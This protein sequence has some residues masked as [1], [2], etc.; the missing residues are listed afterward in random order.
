MRD[1][2]LRSTIPDVTFIEY[3]QNFLA[4]QVPCF[5]KVYNTR[6]KKSVELPLLG[7]A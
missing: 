7:V 1:G 3:T 5:S 4:F 2:I 6:A